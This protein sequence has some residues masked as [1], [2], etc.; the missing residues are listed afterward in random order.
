M[1]SKSALRLQRAGA[2]RL[3]LSLP[4]TTT[5]AVL[6]LR[7]PQRLAAQA[8]AALVPPSS[9][10]C[11]AARTQYAGG[12]NRDQEAFLT[13][14]DPLDVLG[15]DTDCTVEDIDAAFEKMKAQYAPNGPT[16]NAKMVDRAFRAHEILKNPDS[17]YYAKAHTSQTDRQRLQFQLLPKGQR[18]LVQGQVVVLM[19]FAFII[20]FLTIKVCFSPITKPLRAATRS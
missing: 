2:A 15:L 12:S 20:F 11:V 5:T 14:Y 9:A 18:R 17:A 16:P 3:T 19:S 4:T 8:R 1:L 13:Q 10:L 7:R 6:A